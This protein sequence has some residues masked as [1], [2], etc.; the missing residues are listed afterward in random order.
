MGFRI[1]GLGYKAQYIS[2][3]MQGVVLGILE[4]KMEITKVI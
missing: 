3:I 2:I 1:K 4:K